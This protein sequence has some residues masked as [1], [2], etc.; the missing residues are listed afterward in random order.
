MPM[1]SSYRADNRMVWQHRHAH[2]R[3]SDLRLLHEITRGPPQTRGN[4]I[5]GSS[6]RVGFKSDRANVRY[7]QVLCRHD[8]HAVCSDA[9]VARNDP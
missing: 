9:G 1:R 3:G 2:G 8:V 6:P 5:R 7:L 4:G